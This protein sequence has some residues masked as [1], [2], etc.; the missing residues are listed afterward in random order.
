[1]VS[2]YYLGY[3]PSKPP[4]KAP[5]K[6]TGLFDD[7]DDDSAL[8]SAKSSA[9]YVWIFTKTQGAA[10]LMHVFSS[11]FAGQ[12]SLPHRQPKVNFP[13]QMSVNDVM[14]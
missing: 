5:T 9:K 12:W 11:F 6:K 3:S 8:F 7:D 14:S 1:M 2:F 4:Q 13:L 10:S